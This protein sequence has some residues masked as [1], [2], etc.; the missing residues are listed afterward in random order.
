MSFDIFFK[1]NKPQSQNIKS[2]IFIGKKV[3]ANFF[4]T[5]SLNYYAPLF[6]NKVPNTIISHITIR[7]IPPIHPYL[8]ILLFI[9]VKPLLNVLKFRAKVVIEIRRF[10]TPT[11]MY[12]ALKP[13]FQSRPKKRKGHTRFPGALLHLTTI[14]KGPNNTIPPITIPK[15]L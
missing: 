6:P 11:M 10:M 3:W 14:S 2:I 8:M 1:V 13:E 4:P 5:V 12:G 7:A 9:K 15:K